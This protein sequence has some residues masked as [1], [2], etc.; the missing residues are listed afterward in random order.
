MNDLQDTLVQQFCETK[1]RILNSYHCYRNYYDRKAEAQ[2]LKKH[3][4]CLLLNPLLTDQS[5][6]MSKTVQSWLPLYR[7]EQVLTKSKD[8]I[9]T[10]GTPFTQCV[11]RLRIRPI[12]P[13]YIVEDLPRLDPSEFKP[14]PSLSQ[15]RSEPGLF[16]NELPRLLNEHHTN[17]ETLNLHDSESQNEVTTTLSFP[18]VQPALALTRTEPN[19]PRDNT[20]DY[21]LE[22]L[23]EQPDVTEGQRPRRSTRLQARIHPRFPS[24][25]VT[26]VS[27]TVSWF[28]ENDDMPRTLGDQARAARRALLTSQLEANRKTMEA[29]ELL[30][31]S[32][33][34]Q[35]VTRKQ[36]Q[37]VTKNNSSSRS[38][39]KKSI[40]FRSKNKDKQS[41]NSNT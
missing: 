11:H 1:S 8:I 36:T 4:Y 20:T 10:V 35:P 2:P 14:D 5:S 9:R 26:P 24:P 22:R 39:T 34:S 16:D 30:H 15:F 31:Q 17:V 28:S 33:H 41:K 25:T 19:A 29:V 32:T 18:I 7:V 27:H 23:F 6:T 12:K 21:N 38:T 40:F 37:N 13:Q 3:E